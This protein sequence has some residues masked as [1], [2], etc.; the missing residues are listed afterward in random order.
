MPHLFNMGS[1]LCNSTDVVVDPDTGSSG[2]PGT[3]WIDNDCR[4]IF[5]FTTNAKLICMDMER[6][7]IWTEEESQ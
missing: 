2:T 5:E 7:V 1:Y 3:E 4:V 6:N